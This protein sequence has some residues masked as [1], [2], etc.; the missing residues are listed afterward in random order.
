[1]FAKTG[2]SQCEFTVN[3]YN[4]GLSGLKVFPNHLVKN[5]AL[6]SGFSAFAADA[7]HFSG[8]LRTEAAHCL[9]FV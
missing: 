9:R 5:S 6:A 4:I 3:I 1:M 8:H 2:L 7:Y